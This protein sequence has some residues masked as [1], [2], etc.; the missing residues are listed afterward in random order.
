MIAQDYALTLGFLTQGAKGQ[1]EA[2]RAKLE[3]KAFLRA[4][5]SE[6]SGPTTNTGPR[7]GATVRLSAHCVGHTAPSLLGC[8]GGNGH[9]ACLGPLQRTCVRGDV[10]V[11]LLTVPA[12][13]G[14]ADT[15]RGG[16]RR[17]HQAKR[18]TAHTQPAAL[19]GS[20]GAGKAP[21]LT[22]GSL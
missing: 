15:F 22:A 9:T 19:P 14:A 13:F 11:I 6:K 20:T 8:A 18:V 17:A 4:P 7:Q 10:P 12:E 2:L 16:S 1:H 21:N 5:H 3:F